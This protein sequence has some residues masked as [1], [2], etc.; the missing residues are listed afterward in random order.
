M[1]QMNFS[2]NGTFIRKE[3]EVD[4]C[5][6]FTFEGYL[7][8]PLSIIPLCMKPEAIY[9]LE[10]HTFSIQLD[11]TLSLL[12]EK[13]QLR[14]CS[15]LKIAQLEHLTGQVDDVASQK[16]ALSNMCELPC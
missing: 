16:A 9:L 5:S 1:A 15:S 4:H 14:N 3:C 6:T 10:L 2:E 11:Q 8:L 13:K 7:S 12:A